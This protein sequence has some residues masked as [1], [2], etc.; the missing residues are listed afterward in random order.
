MSLSLYHISVLSPCAGS[1]R[2]LVIK[3]TKMNPLMLHVKTSKC[4]SVNLIYTAY[5]TDASNFM[6]QELCGIN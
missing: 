6:K 5:C 2:N 3:L 4:Y 1:G